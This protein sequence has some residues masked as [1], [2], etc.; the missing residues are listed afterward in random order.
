MKDKH[1]GFLLED[2]HHKL[3][4]VLEATDALS[5]VPGQLRIIEARL[6]QVESQTALIPVIRA[7]VTDQSRELKAHA[8]RLSELEHIDA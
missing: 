8:S 3:S 7:A 2:M 5:A 6:E 4:Q 1:L